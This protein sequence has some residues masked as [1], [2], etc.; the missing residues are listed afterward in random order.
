M[1]PAPQQVFSELSNDANN[2]D[3]FPVVERGP[4]EA[5]LDCIMSQ[6]GTTGHEW[7][8]CPFSDIYDK[9][10]TCRVTSISSSARRRLHVGLQR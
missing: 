9:G 10:D 1:E 3:V 8:V 7:A 2:A 4:E 6:I 5:E